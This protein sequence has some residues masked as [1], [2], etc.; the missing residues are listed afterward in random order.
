[1]NAVYVEYADAQH[2][3]E[4]YDIARV[5]TSGSTS[6]SNSPAQRAELHKVL[7]ALEHC[8]NA[9]ACRNAAAPSTATEPTPIPQ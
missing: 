9:T 5:R 7:I 1:M 8:H 2:E 3:I 4:Y 6:R